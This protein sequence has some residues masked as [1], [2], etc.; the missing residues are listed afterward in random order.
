MRLLLSRKI[1]AP[2]KRILLVAFLV[3]ILLTLLFRS[4]NQENDIDKI[5]NIDATEIVDIRIAGHTITE[6]TSIAEIT[7][8]MNDV[9]AF[10]FQQGGCYKPTRM[11]VLLRSGEVLQLAVAIKRDERIALIQ[12][13]GDDLPPCIYG[14][15][16]YS[17]ALPQVFI[18]QGINI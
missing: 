3:V 1:D 11:I 15:P 7:S 6:E 14:R 5:S 16:M 8:A 10:T 13:I 17:K 18:H 2:Y 4:I 9:R 12:L